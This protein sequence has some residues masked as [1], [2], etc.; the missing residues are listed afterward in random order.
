M[1]VIGGRVTRLLDPTDPE[2]KF[3]AFGLV[4]YLGS[5]PLTIKPG[6]FLPIERLIKIKPLPD[7]E[8]IRRPPPRP[9]GIWRKLLKI[10]RRQ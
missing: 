6:I 4:R 7:P 8:L 5:T 3:A 9:N 1:I 10:E 2:S